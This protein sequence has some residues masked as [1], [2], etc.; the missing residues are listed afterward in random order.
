[1]EALGQAVTLAKKVGRTP[2]GHVSPAGGG[3]RPGTSAADQSLGALK[4]P[5]RGGA[6]LALAGP[7]EAG[8]PVPGRPEFHAHSR[9][10][11]TYLGFP[12]TVAGPGIGG[13][14]T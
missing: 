13:L 11:S 1:M 6:R 5:G 14:G 7:Q 10:S 8:S 4:H 2:G 12:Q 3:G 9:R